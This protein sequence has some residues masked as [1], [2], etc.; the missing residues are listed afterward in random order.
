MAVAVAAAVVMSARFAVGRSIAL[1]I[2]LMVVAAATGTPARLGDVG[3]R[4]FLF[5][6]AHCLGSTV[7]GLACAFPV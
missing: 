4:G 1:T 2:A 5:F 7:A 6:R 3:L